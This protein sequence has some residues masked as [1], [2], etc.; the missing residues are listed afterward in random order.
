MLSLSADEPFHLQCRRQRPG[1]EEFLINPDDCH[2]N[3]IVYPTDP[4][5]PVTHPDS[6]EE[7]EKSYSKKESNTGE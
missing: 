1:T 5:E 6:S 3:P 7:E 2:P 4:E